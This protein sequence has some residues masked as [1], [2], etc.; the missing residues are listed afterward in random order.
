MRIGMA[1]AISMSEM[2]MRGQ[3]YDHQAHLAQN[4][5]WQWGQPAED[6]LS[7]EAP[8]TKASRL[9]LLQFSAAQR[10]SFSNDAPTD[11]R[12]SAGSTGHS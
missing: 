4:A 1:M 11:S 8:P 6:L 5:F 10:S 7:F 9:G 3:S 2:G 12:C